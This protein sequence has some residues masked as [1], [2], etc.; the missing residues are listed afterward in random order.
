MAA[1]VFC[2]CGIFHGVV[3]RGFM[4]LSRTIKIYMSFRT[5]LPKGREPAIGQI[6]FF[7]IVR[8]S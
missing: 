4:D 2:S 1:R 6:E 7:L 8:L 5:A 3:F